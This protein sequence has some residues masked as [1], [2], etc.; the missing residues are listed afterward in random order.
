VRLG[1][2]QDHARTFAAAAADAEK[3]TFYMKANGFDVIEERLNASE[4]RLAAFK[5]D[6]QAQQEQ[7]LA[8][9]LPAMLSGSY[10]LAV[11]DSRHLGLNSF[12]SLTLKT[13]MKAVHRWVLQEKEER[14]GVVEQTLQEMAEVDTWQAEVGHLDRCLAWCPVLQ[15][16]EEVA[17]KRATL[18]EHGPRQLQ[19]VRA[20]R[21]PLHAL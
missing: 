7:L 1:V 13:G 18:E 8:R 15:L 5:E 4:E 21:L 17:A 11:V 12:A 16:R 19:E 14:L 10:A 3:Y 20:L 2:P 6:L 9:A